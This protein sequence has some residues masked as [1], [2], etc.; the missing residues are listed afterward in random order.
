MFRPA[1]RANARRVRFMFFGQ[2]ASTLSRIFRVWRF[3]QCKGCL[4]KKHETNTCKTDANCY[5]A[6]WNSQLNT[7][8][9]CAIPQSGC[10]VRIALPYLPPDDPIPRIIQA[11]MMHQVLG[12]VKLML[13]FG[14]ILIHLVKRDAAGRKP[15]R[16]PCTPSNAA[17]KTT[18]GLKSS[19]EGIVA[20]QP[21]D[22]KYLGCTLWV[23][24]FATV[25]RSPIRLCPGLGL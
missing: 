11:F 19:I 13:V 6:K 18:V 9:N 12:C 5:P 20:L 4:A 10:R 3:K 21:P 17:A 16:T 22:Q 2:G 25:R 7:S 1:N 14:C 23:R 8:S 24:H 15:K